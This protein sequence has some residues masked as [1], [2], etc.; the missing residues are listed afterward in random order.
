MIRQIRNL[1]T[2]YQWIRHGMC[3]LT[4][5]NSYLILSA[6]LWGFI[7]KKFEEES[8]C[9]NHNAQSIAFHTFLDCITNWSHLGKTDT[10]REF[11]NTI[12]PLLWFI[13]TLGFVCHYNM[14]VWI[15]GGNGINI[16]ITMGLVTLHMCWVILCVTKA[17][18]SHY[19]FNGNHWHHV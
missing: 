15:W 13:L 4:N 18:T 14:T 2:A 5:V 7:H 1:H 11:N 10:Q 8:L 12:T 6:K 9:V 16:S 3:L 19:T 17:S